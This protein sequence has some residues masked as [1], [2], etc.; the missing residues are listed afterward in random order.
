MMNC[1][2]KLSHPP[3]KIWHLLLLPSCIFLAFTTIAWQSF[4]SINL[5]DK[6]G[7]PVPNL[8]YVHTPWWLVIAAG[9]LLAFAAFILFLWTQYSLMRPV[10]STSGPVELF[11]SGAVPL[12]AM[13]YFIY[14]VV[15]G[16]LFAT[17]SVTLTAVR[18]EFDPKIALITMK[19]ERGDNWVSEI[20]SAA[21]TTGIPYQDAMKW[22]EANFPRR[23]NGTL[24]LAPKEETETMFHIELE[25]ETEDVF[26]TARIITYGIMW[27]M[28]SE[29]FAL[30]LIRPAKVKRPL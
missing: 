30:A 29:S 13:L 6:K 3:V 20:A 17:T 24:R 26:I 11:L 22:Q 7:A 2:I 28:A 23:T 27:P 19:L 5:L 10:K 9:L 15:A 1:I 25:N 14:Q 21:V 4:S 18:D 16:A 12:S 8:T